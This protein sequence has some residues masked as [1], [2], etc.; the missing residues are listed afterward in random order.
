[1]PSMLGY[2]FVMPRSWPATLI[3]AP[4]STTTVPEA[5]LDRHGVHYLTA[6]VAGV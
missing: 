6:Y 5:N 1:M 3:L 4:P 2:H